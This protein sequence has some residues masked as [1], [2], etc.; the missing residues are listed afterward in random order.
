MDLRELAELLLAKVRQARGLDPALREKL[1]NALSEDGD[2]RIVR[3]RVTE[4]HMEDDCTVD[5]WLETDQSYKLR[6]P[7]AKFLLEIATRAG[8]EAIH[9]KIGEALARR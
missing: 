7:T 2:E 1:V 5:I 4:I 9:T 6:D 8:L 3:L